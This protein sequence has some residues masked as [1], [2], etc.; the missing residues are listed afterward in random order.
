[1]TILLATVERAGYA[2]VQDGGR[3]G[4]THVGVPT[5]G[6]FHRQRYLAATALL[7]GIPDPRRPAIEVLAGDLQL[8]MAAESVL[9]LV[10]PGTLHVDGDACAV[11]AA[12]LVPSTGRGGMRRPG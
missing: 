12:V 8:R 9:A 6:A 3:P 11:G 7:S 4:L 5:S 10:G 1:M 2:T